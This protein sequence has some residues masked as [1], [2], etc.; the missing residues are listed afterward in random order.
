M[1]AEATVGLI[2]P[3]ID[4]EATPFPSAPITSQAA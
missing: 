1:Q 4:G 2:P 3:T